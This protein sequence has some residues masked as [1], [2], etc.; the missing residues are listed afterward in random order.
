MRTLSLKLIILFIVL[1]PLFGTAQN[2]KI[3]GTVFDSTG[4]APLKNS[5]I[6]AVRIQDSLLLGF[7][8]S[9][10]DGNFKL[11]EFPIDTFSLVVTYPKCDD[12]TYLIFGS[13]SNYEVTISKIILQPESK[14][15]EAVVIY[16]NK[17][18]IY[19]K[20]D[21]LVYVADSFKVAENAVVEDLL[22]KLPGIKVEKDGTIKS[23]GKAISKVLVDGDEFFGND[24]TIATKNLAAKGVESVQVYEKKDEN[25]ADGDETIQVMD[26]K[27]KEEA[28][29]GYFGRSSFATDFTNFY[30]GE[31]LANKFNGT[32]KIS[33]FALGSNTPVSKFNWGESQEFGLNNE[34][35]MSYD[36]DGNSWTTSNELNGIPQTYKAGLYFSDKIGK[37]KKTKIDFNYS[38]T[39]SKVN[40]YS[41]SRSQYFLGDT[42]YFSDDSTHN[43]QAAQ[44][45]RFNFSLILQI[46]SLTT[47]TLKPKVNFDISQIDNLDNTNFISENNVLTRSNLINT[48]NKTKALTFENETTINRL[49]K[50]PKREL[51]ATYNFSSKL[52]SSTGKL[53]S[54][55]SFLDDFIFNDTTDQQKKFT[56]SNELHTAKLKFIEPI[57]KKISIEFEYNF[58]Y[59]FSFQN[60]ETRNRL[61]GDYSIL[62]SDFSNKFEN[63]RQ[64]NK[65]GAML[66]YKTKKYSISGGSRIRNIEIVNTNLITNSVVSQSLN[67]VLPRLVLTFNPTMSKRINVRY[68]TESKQPSI[69]DLQPVPDNSNPNRVVKGNPNLKPN[70]SHNLGIH[71]NTW[72]ALSGR[73]V[74]A[75]LN[76]N[77]TNNAFANSIK[78]DSVLIGKMESQTVNVNGNYNVNIYSGTGFNVFK[79]LLFIRPNLNGNY[80]KS[81]NLINGINNSTIFRTVESELELSVN[82]D[83]LTMSLSGSLS[84]TSPLNSISTVSNTPYTTKSIYGG[85]KIRLPKHFIV[86]TEATYTMNGNRGDGYNINFLIWNAEISKAFLKTENLIL[87]VVGNDILNQNISANRLVNG[88]VI[89]DNKTKIISRYFLLKLTFKFN[90]NKTKED[91][92]EEDNW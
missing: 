61:N 57:T 29:K 90:N 52:N 82:K 56:N 2:I 71:L 28:K 12:R 15:L 26:L 14:E 46:D 48:N 43:Y 17:N 58:E 5:V 68:S 54:S 1:V 39:D 40:A 81:S 8:Y 78:F 76:G 77:V 84:Y 23:Q 83:S 62:N 6:M 25:S 67:N 32:Q 88:N 9:D 24:A 42:T 27:L 35:D 73:Y 37:K 49:F 69:N 85:F 87:S 11:K 7:T 74:Y 21:T 80:S 41:K 44:K 38:F 47:L 79:K 64:Q 72:E 59:G 53:F 10:T 18:P 91:D 4:L 33:V 86:S 50:K 31:F 13:A 16:A 63:V 30:Q 51:N 36:E 60:K 22:K 45:H 20:G 65:L 92:A 75:G 70:Y 34:E 19:Y 55:N 66:M 3:S 89:T